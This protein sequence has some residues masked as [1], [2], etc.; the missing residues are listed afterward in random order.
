MRKKNKSERQTESWFTAMGEEE[1]LPLVF[2]GRQS[3][4]SG[5]DES[6]YPSLVSIFWPYEPDNNGMPD[7]ETNDAQIELEDALEELDAAGVSLLMLVV[8]GNGRKEW[9]WYVCD[10]GSWMEELN[11]L[12]AD[13]P[14]FPIEIENRH[15][16]DWAMYHGFISGVDGI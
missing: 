14:V 10:V 4:P 5:V 11:R 7:A 3:V 15:E 2:R 1:G 6:D 8:T 12:L 9:H 16:P 13:H